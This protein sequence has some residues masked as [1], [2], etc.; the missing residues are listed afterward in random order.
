MPTPRYYDVGIRLVEK[1]IPFG[2]DKQEQTTTKCGDSSPSASLRVRM[3]S[4]GVRQNDGDRF[5]A[6]AL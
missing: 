2:N 5:G 1:Q 6:K 3:T 4:K